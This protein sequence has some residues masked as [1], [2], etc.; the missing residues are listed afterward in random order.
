MRY[1]LIETGGEYFLLGH[2]M[3]KEIG[4]FFAERHITGEWGI[5]GTHSKHDLVHDG[6]EVVASTK[7]LPNTHRLDRATVEKVVAHPKIF[8]QEDIRSAMMHMKR[9]M[10]FPKE[11]QPEDPLV[12]I[13]NYETQLS[14]EWM[15]EVELKETGIAVS[16]GFIPAG[17]I[18]GKGLQVHRSYEP[19]VKNGYITIR[20]AK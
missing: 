4:K 17:V 5:Y 18:G 10:E 11:I 1:K 16:G 6:T 13:S 9:Y 20:S 8:T 19:L 7:D 2:S 15:C 12:V 3:V 14:R